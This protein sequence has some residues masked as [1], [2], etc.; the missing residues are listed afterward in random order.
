M[1]DARGEYEP[2]ENDRGE[3]SAKMAT[4][5]N[6]CRREEGD[7]YWTES[8][9]DF[10]EVWKEPGTGGR[11]SRLRKRRRSVEEEE[12]EVDR[13][14][15]MVERKANEYEHQKAKLMQSYGEQRWEEEDYENERVEEFVE[16]RYQDW[17]NREEECAGKY[18]DGSL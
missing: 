16:S 10:Q 11:E 14:R 9:V 4:M 1:E 15:R 12:T 6:W 3:V 13:A 17:A 8:E 18:F 5:L 7:V 2:R